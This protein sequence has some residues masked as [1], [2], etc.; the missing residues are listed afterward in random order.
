MTPRKARARFTIRRDSLSSISCRRSLVNVFPSPNPHFRN[1]LCRK[2]C[3][4]IKT[5]RGTAV[6]NRISAG[7]SAEMVRRPGRILGSSDR[8]RTDLKQRASSSQTNRRPYRK[9][10]ILKLVEKTI[11]RGEAHGQMT[12]RNSHQQYSRW[13]D[14]WKR[15]G[16]QGVRWHRKTP[17]QIEWNTC[18][19]VQNRSIFKFRPRPQTPLAPR[20]AA[21]K[22]RGQREVRRPGFCRGLWKVL[23]PTSSMHPTRSESLIRIAAIMRNIRLRFTRPPINGRQSSRIEFKQCFSPERKLFDRISHFFLHFHDPPSRSHN[24]FIAVLHWPEL[25]PLKFGS[26]WIPRSTA[27]LHIYIGTLYFVHQPAAFWDE[28]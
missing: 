5:S 12:R 1:V 28:M 6:S 20:P 16:R 26:A 4:R 17:R 7:Q 15:D 27:Y 23:N 3:Q 10:L 9:T 13:C 18:H 19:A 24:P 11:S 22:T 2:G 8:A 21:S 14:E 25:W